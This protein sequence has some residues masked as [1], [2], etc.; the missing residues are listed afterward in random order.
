MI[1][2]FLMTKYTDTPVRSDINNN[3]SPGV[4]RCAVGEEIISRALTL[5]L[6]CG[7]SFASRQLDNECIWHQHLPKCLPVQSLLLWL[8]PAALK[9]KR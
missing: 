6:L 3:A 2:F 1:F 7:V 5:Q 9:L 4:G 8:S